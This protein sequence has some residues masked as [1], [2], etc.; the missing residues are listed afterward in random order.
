MQLTNLEI[1]NFE[2]V[3]FMNLDIAQ[4]VMLIA[5]DNNSGKTSVRDAIHFAVCG[6]SGRVKLKKDYTQLVYDGA[7]PKDATISIT[8]DGNQFK[9]AVTTGKGSDDIPDWPLIFPFLDGF[10]HLAQESRDEIQRIIA[11][12]TKVRPTKAK[13]S[14]ML[15]EYGVA[16]NHIALVL[17]MLSA[18]FVAAHSQAKSRESEAKGAWQAIT[19]E[20]Y[21]ATKAD[22]WECEAPD[23]KS[24]EDIKALKKDLQKIEKL[25]DEAAD[26]FK[27]MRTEYGVTQDCPECG[28]SLNYNSSTGLTVA[29]KGTDPKE[30]TA[31][32]K[33]LADLTNKVI[34]I[35]AEITAAENSS[36]DVERVTKEA[37]KHHNLVKEWHVVAEALSPSGIPL[38]VTVE[39]ITPINKRLEN[40]HSLTEWPLIKLEK[41][42]SI[43]AG[44]RPYG[45][46]SE[47]EMWRA[48]AALAE[49]LSIAS[50]VK[51]FVLDRMDVLSPRNRA[52]LI[53]W[54]GKVSIDHD[55]IIIIATL[56][57]PPAKLPPGFESVWIQDG[58]IAEVE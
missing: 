5:G 46:L 26:N 39:A 29:G 18:G 11:K 33:L 9:R 15:Q 19:G 16:D 1:R 34:N 4:S 43:T 41:D 23:G 24:A 38:T 12:I 13:V 58:L 10:K 55:T 36:K 31:A 7:K 50:G 54:L 51:L 30:Y 32:Q 53:K 20:K 21:G 47:S 14:K 40:T 25:R 37:L 2:G 28:V 3:H 52:I 35:E 6:D 17:P 57:T 49:A 56:K 48:D 42:L 22:S 44:G 27:G 8:L 45:L